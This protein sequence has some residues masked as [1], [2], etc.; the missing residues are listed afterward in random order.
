MLELMDL[1]QWIIKVAVVIYVVW[2]IYDGIKKMKEEK[3]KKK[4]GEVYDI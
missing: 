2:F 1:V 3:D 4:R